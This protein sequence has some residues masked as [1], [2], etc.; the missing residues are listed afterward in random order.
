M[1]ARNRYRGQ[2]IRFRSRGL[3]AIDGSDIFNFGSGACS[4]STH[5]QVVQGA[6]IERDKFIFRLLGQ[7]L[8]LA[9]GVKAARDTALPNGGPTWEDFED[10]VVTQHRSDRKEVLNN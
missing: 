1:S 8:E 2:G 6:K 5:A 3:Q 7:L 9:F 4:C 10:M